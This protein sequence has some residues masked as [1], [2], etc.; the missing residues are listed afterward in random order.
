MKILKIELCAMIEAMAAV[1]GEEMF[2]AVLVSQLQV[3]PSQFEIEFQR[4]RSI[5]RQLAAGP[6]DFC[7]ATVSPRS[8]NRFIF[9]SLPSTSST[10]SISASSPGA[11]WA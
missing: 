3:T 10:P 11:R 4:G 1:G 2:E 6:S 7:G 9:L 8:F 5:S